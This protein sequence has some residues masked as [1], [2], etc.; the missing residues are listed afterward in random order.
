MQ[1][2][3]VKMNRSAEIAL[4]R[5]ESDDNEEAAAD[6]S[7]VEVDSDVGCGVAA[8]STGT[9][10]AT[11][12]LCTSERR[13]PRRAAENGSADTDVYR[14]EDRVNGHLGHSS[15]ISWGVGF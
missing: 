15:L 11:L 1:S 14:A 12:S 8:L 4:E 10:T 13:H 2:G 9:L 3:Q 5:E 6:E 7:V